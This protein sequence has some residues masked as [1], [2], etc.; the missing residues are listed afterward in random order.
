MA[1]FT[2]FDQDGNAH[3]VDVG[4][5]SA[6]ARV[7]V[8]K[9]Y[10]QMHPDTLSM[11]IEG[12]ARKGDV[13]GVARLAGIMGAKQTAALIPLCHPLSLDHVTIDLTPDPTLPGIHITA[14]CAVTGPT[15]VE[16]E[17]M[18]AVSTA[19]LTIYDMCKAVDRGMQIGGIRLT[20]KSGG[21]SGRYDAE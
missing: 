21:K 14:T 13:L 11:I 9:G 17:A 19:S 15:G 8:V 7:A 3:M 10:V 18:T 20:H 2:H 6:T 4:A 12:T 5:K 16:M 1:E